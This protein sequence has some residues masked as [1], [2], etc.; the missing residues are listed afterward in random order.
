MEGVH[1]SNGAPV[2]F[3]LEKDHFDTEHRSSL[4]L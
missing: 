1:T 4:K 2:I 3:E